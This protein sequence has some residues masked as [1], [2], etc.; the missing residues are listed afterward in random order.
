VDPKAAVKAAAVTERG[1]RSADSGMINDTSQQKD[2]LCEPSLPM[3]PLG[4]VIS[5]QHAAFD[6]KLQVG[7][8]HA[9]FDRMSDLEVFHLGDFRL[10]MQQL[11]FTTMG[12]SR[13]SKS[14]EVSSVSWRCALDW[15]SR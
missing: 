8:K 3:I 13:K 6:D 5:I 11:G 7:H 12:P 4:P 10:P 1:S 14:F 2:I 15:K 9:A